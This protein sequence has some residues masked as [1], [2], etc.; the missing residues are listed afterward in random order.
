MPDGPLV[1]GRA[2]PGKI[3]PCERSALGS[4][5][6]VGEFPAIEK[7]EPFLPLHL[8]QNYQF[9][10]STLLSGFSACNYYAFVNLWPKAVDNP[11]DQ[12]RGD[13]R[14]TFYGLVALSFGYGQAA[15]CAFPA[16]TG[17]RKPIIFLM[18]ITFPLL[19]AA[20]TDPLG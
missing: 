16:W 4:L 1:W 15:F 10:A 11:Y 3:G 8:F 12:V 19:A 7:V 17:P 18:I 6:P 2:N 14:V 5:H 9:M 20:G 13:Y